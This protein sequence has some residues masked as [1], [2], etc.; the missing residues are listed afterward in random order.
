LSIWIVKEKNIKTPGIIVIGDV[1]NYRDALN[2]FE[3]LP[4]FNKSIGITRP[5]KQN[6]SLVK[7]IRDLGGKPIELP[8]IKVKKINEAALEKA[9]DELENYSWLIFTSVNAVEIFF[10]KIDE[11]A[12]DLRALGAIKVAVVGNS[13]KKK[14]R[15]Y[16]IKADLIP[17]E[18]TGA[19]LGKLLVKTL[20]PNE[21]ILVPRSIKGKKKMVKILEAKAIINDLPIYDLVQPKIDEEVIK[22]PLDYITFTSP[23]T[24]NNFASQVKRSYMENTKIISI[25]PITSK[26]IRNEGFDV[27]KEAINHSIVGLVEILRDENNDKY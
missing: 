22:Q 4:L 14:L 23:S 8:T 18:Y 20:N 13:T 10:E 26:A 15:E 16:G 17:K 24:F 7:A 3:N 2:Y 1:I 25:G 5:K 11:M 9:I 19:S 12:L 21:K 27:Y 6:N